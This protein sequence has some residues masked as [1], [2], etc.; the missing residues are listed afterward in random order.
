MNKNKMNQ[1]IGV[2]VFSTMLM[3][4]GATV[5]VSPGGDDAAAGTSAD[6]VRTLRR[7]Q[8]L[9]RAAKRGGAEVTI[10]L[11]GGEYP[12]SESL[13]LDARDSGC[14]WMAEKDERPV[15]SGRRRLSGL[16]AVS[17]PAMRARFPVAV[18]DAVREIDAK[19]CGYRGFEPY[20]TSGL[21]YFLQHTN[22]VRRSNALYCGRRRL[23][24]A[25]GPNEGFV[26]I[27][28]VAKEWHEIVAPIPEMAQITPADAPDLVASGYFCY[29]WDDGN[30]RADVIDAKSGTVRLEWAPSYGVVNEKNTM[31]ACY[32]Q[33]APALLDRP[34]EWYLDRASG[35]VYVLPPEGA[36]DDA[37]SMAE[38]ADEF[39]VVDG[40][41]GVRIEGLVFECG[42]GDAVRM[43]NA[44]DVAFVGNVVRDFGGIGL[45][46]HGER[47][48]ISG[49]VLHDF[50][51]DAIQLTSGDRQMLVA[52]G[53]VVSGNDISRSGNV[54]RCYTP[55]IWLGGCGTQ[56]ANNHFHDLPSSAMRLEGN[57]FDIVSNLVERVVQESD[58]QGGSDMWFNPSYAGNRF[59]YNVWRDFSTR[60]PTR[61]GWAGI[62]FDD[63]ISNQKVYCNRFERCSAKSF[64]GVQIHGGRCN[65]VSNN[66]FVACRY[67][68]SLSTWTQ[69]KWRQFLEKG[70]PYATHEERLYRTPVYA[71]HYPGIERLAEVP[72]VNTVCCNVLV[73]AKRV[74]H[75]NDGNRASSSVVAHDN[76]MVPRMPDAAQLKSVPG[77]EMPPTA[78]EVG[79]RADDPLFAVARRNDRD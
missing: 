13:V 51:F 35:K 59:R 73:G 77:F 55:G 78:E 43:T 50:G 45:V 29:L 7:A 61:V 57:D 74:V 60:K 42:R 16:R 58:D 67:G 2:L 65:L 79:P 9:A 1:I 24:L 25:R 28:S 8:E 34:G 66:L 32:Y 6:P 36:A 19:A 18:R 48:T 46:V 4:S 21:F 11:R 40:A 14:T 12:V 71:A 3:A 10:R 64:G 56:L 68:V 76:L 70:N 38:F 17:D 33:N 44:T 52:S 41:R 20:S 72:M 49:N 47:L 39:L 75:V 37:Y 53:T 54:Q 27:T 62:R 69:N 23:T 15:L 31:P 26:R 30:V 22:A 63:A 5:T